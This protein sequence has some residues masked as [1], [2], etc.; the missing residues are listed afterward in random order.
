MPV[1]ADLQLTITPATC[2]EG[3]GICA[4]C[5]GPFFG[6]ITTNDPAIKAPLQGPAPTPSTCASFNP[7]AGTIVTVAG[8]TDVYTFTNSS[9][10]ACV[11]VQLEAPCLGPTNALLSSALVNGPHFTNCADLLGFSGLITNSPASYSFNLPSNGV[12]NVTVSGGGPLFGLGLC[13]NYTL[14][15]DGFECAPSLGIGRAGANRIVFNW[16]TFASD[17][18]LQC[19]TNVAFTNAV[20]VTNTP[21]AIGGNFVLTNDTAGPRQFYRLRKP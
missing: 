4:A 10:A 15:V 9:A 2:A 17:Y 16:P 14:R 19:T 3:G 21:S 20:T 11:T 8:P 13:S 1:I 5:N 12:F 6:S 18:Q 7:C